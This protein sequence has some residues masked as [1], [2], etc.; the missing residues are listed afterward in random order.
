MVFGRELDD[1]GADPVGVLR[2]HPKSK[3]AYGRPSK[4][5]SHELE[6]ERAPE[7]FSVIGRNR[8]LGERVFSQNLSHPDLHAILPSAARAQAEMPASVARLYEHAACTA[9]TLTRQPGLDAQVDL[10]S[11]DGKTG[12]GLR[13]G[14]SSAVRQPLL[15]GAA[16]LGTSK[17]LG[18]PP[19][20]PAPLDAYYGV[21]SAELGERPQ[22]MSSHSGEARSHKAIGPLAACYTHGS[23][24]HAG[25]TSDDDV[26]D[27]LRRDDRIF[28]RAAGVPSAHIAQYASEGQLGTAEVAPLNARPERR[29]APRAFPGP[30]EQSAAL[31]LGRERRV[32]EALL[33]AAAAAAA[34]AVVAGRCAVGAVEV[35]AGCGC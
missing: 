29:S 33:S 4:R 30:L 28:A 13:P 16:L 20:P 27:A 10:M 15:R 25:V 21:G 32:E 8:R 5:E 19:A 34:A 26:S 35:E 11:P 22:R 31:Q 14:S 1:S 7:S 24:A 18:A 17:K 3:G 2:Q 9:K 23:L 12:K 6:Y